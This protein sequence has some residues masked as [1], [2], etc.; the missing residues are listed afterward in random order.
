MNQLAFLNLTSFTY[1]YVYTYVQ[2][3]NM[4]VCKI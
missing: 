2:I 1:M 4:H 3:L